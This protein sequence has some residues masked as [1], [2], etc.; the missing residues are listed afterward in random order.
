MK[1]CSNTNKYT[2]RNRQKMLT[3]KQFLT[4]TKN[5]HITHVEDLILE[6][7]REGALDALNFLASVTK[8]ITGQTTNHFDL[9]VKY[10]GAP[11]IFCG[12]N[13]EN[14]KFFVATKSIFAKNAK[15]NY[16]S[17][18]VD[19][20]HSGTLADKLKIALRYL[21]ALGIKKIIQGDL[22]FTS[23]DIKSE[24]INGEEYITFQPNVIVYAIPISD[25]SLVEKITKAKI[26]IVFHTSYSGETLSNLKA[27]YKVNIDSFNKTLNV[28]FDDA[29]YHDKSGSVTLTVEES[30]TIMNDVKMAYDLLKKI[31]ANELTS[32]IQNTK[33]IDLI[34]MH[35][36]AKIRDGN[37]IED[38]NRHIQDMYEF[39][40]TRLENEK[41]KLTN[42]KAK[43]LRDATKE[44]YYS[45]MN[46]AKSLILNVFTFQQLLNN[47]KLKLLKKLN[48]V[49]GMGT[50]VKNGSEF[51]ITS[52]E[53]FVAV[54][55]LSGNVVKLV[56]RLNFS[57]IN[58][59]TQKTW[60]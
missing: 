44:K 25:K 27:T 56:D 37:H 53:G 38:V 20:N 45:I 46:N 29:T 18:D 31:N 1:N 41:E 7:G 55:H 35:L 26:G 40:H 17:S 51:L 24:T 32:F 6:R 22:M 14:G 8:S 2:Q 5:I 33:L 12:I 49:K 42:K 21:P 11:S 30:A 58:F 43:Q 36:N 47:I 4:E 19:K 10:D 54:D 50:F 60:K 16:T 52:P 15:L 28:W 23:E 48:T 13:P 39:I 59:N 9:T 3:F 57:R 34:K